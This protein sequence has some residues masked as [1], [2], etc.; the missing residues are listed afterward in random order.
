VGPESSLRD[1]KVFR[2]GLKIMGCQSSQLLVGLYLNNGG[3]K[4]Q[5]KRTNYSIKITLLQSRALSRIYEVIQHEYVEIICLSCT[6]LEI[7]FRP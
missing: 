7:V 6:P 5:M 4:F 1:I 3:S 2:A